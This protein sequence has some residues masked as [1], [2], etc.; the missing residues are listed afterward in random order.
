MNRTSPLLLV[1][2]SITTVALAVASAAIYVHQSAPPPSTESLAVSDGPPT[3][4]PLPSAPPPAAPTPLPQAVLAPDAALPDVVEHVLP[5]V[6]NIA[7]MHMATRS[8]YGGPSDGGGQSLG[9]G[10]VVSED[11]LVVTNNHVVEGGSS[12]RV[13]FADGHEYSATIVGTDDLTDIALLRITP[14][15]GET[16][17]L[18][19]V[20]YGESSAL[21]LGDTVL[22]IGNPFGVGQT[23]TMGIVSAVGRADMGIAEYE[24]FI[25]TDASINPGNSG[26]ALVSMRGELVGINTAIL[27]GGGGG[28]GG[29]GGSVGI[30]FAI[31][32]AMVR[33]IVESLLAH[34]RVTRGWLG[35]SLQ[36]VNA[37]LA[38]AM[39]A[40]ATQGVLVT[41]VEPG[42][43]ADDAG[44]VRGDI[45]EQ[46]DTERLTSRAQLRNLVA[47]RG[48]GSHVQLTIE[49]AGARRTL[50][51][52][53]EP[54]PGSPAIAQRGAPQIDPR[55]APRGSAP[56]LDPWAVPPA[57]GV[58]GAPMFPPGWGGPN[59]PPGW[60]TGQS[61]SMPMDPRGVDPRG[62]D[63]R[64]VDPRGV[65]PRLGP[66]PPTGM[67]ATVDVG[68]LAVADLDASARAMFRIPAAIA[69]GAVVTAVTRGSSGDAAGVDVGDVIIETNGAAV[70]SAADFQRAY[71]SAGGSAVVLLRRGGGS[72]YVLMR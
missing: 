69:H 54:R 46:L 9:S 43:P 56:P 47:T 3:P 25:Q 59:A 10:V 22:A 27:S 21:R 29:R 50:P 66:P 55:A 5:G 51:A 19:P 8:P 12:I 72:T 65:D 63:P 68:G 11:G 49:R 71:A 62:V 23:V 28:S 52:V 53:L 38:R 42:S 24:D 37:D 20:A 41:D 64:A 4:D 16:L 18:T 44:L 60:G 31:P 7:S 58:P 30:G 45:I 1:S 40:V 17:H 6:V 26:G 32:T 13:H 15:A 67:P 70:S 48:A 61:P 33:P 34:G 14:P 57:F 39:H 35:V 2:W 36:D